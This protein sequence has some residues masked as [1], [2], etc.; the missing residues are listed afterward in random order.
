MNKKP[1]THPWAHIRP[2]TCT[3]QI[4]GHVKDDVKEE[5]VMQSIK[6]SI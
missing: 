2:Q 5:M 1:S 4:R 6:M 3:M